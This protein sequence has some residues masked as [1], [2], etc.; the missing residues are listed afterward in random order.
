MGE[1]NTI[2]SAYTINNA[3]LFSPYTMYSVTLF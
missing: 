3:T 2:R 1:W